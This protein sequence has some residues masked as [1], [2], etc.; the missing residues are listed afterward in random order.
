ME[1][2][3]PNHSLILYP[4]GTYESLKIRNY[5]SCIDSVGTTWLNLK[6][7]QS[8]TGD[9]LLPSVDPRG[10]WRCGDICTNLNVQNTARIGTVTDPQR[11]LTFRFMTQIS[12]LCALKLPV[13]A[14][15]SATVRKH[16]RVGQ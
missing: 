9:R 10:L 8:Y 2:D 3:K 13:D 4:S 14:S 6:P 11:W 12:G 7:S 1:N 16:V 15:E 5:V